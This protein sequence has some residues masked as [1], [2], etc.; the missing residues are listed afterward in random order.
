MVLSIEVE[1]LILHKE[2][3][4]VRIED[5]IKITETGSYLIDPGAETGISLNPDGRID[6]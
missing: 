3:D 6:E 1:I 2:V 4:H 5:M